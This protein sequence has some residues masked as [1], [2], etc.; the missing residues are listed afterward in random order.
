MWKVMRKAFQVVGRSL[1][2]I[3]AESRPGFVDARRQERWFIELS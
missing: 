3:G 2:G 1:D